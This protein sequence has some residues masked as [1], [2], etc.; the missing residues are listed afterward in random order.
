M[1][2]GDIRDGNVYQY[3]R[4]LYLN[5]ISCHHICFD[6]LAMCGYWAMFGSKLREKLKQP[7]TLKRFNLLMGILLA[8]SGISVLLQ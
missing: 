8:L 2:E 1:D 4:A 5:I 3:D 6:K 7:S